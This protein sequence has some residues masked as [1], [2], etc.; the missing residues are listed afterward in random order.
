MIDDERSNVGDG[1]FI[2]EPIEVD[3]DKDK[4]A[5]TAFVWRDQR[6]EIIEILHEWQD[7]SVPGYAHARGWIH[8]RH[9]NYYVVRTA[10]EK[11]FEI[12]LDRPPKR[13]EWVLLKRKA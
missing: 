9:R 13:R 12:Y 11:I 1:E 2:S 7:W 5:P 10:D 3:Y 4:L 6:Y 8:R